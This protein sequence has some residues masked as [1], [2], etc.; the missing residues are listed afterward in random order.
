[1]REKV[2]GGGGGGGEETC[3]SV[4]FPVSFGILG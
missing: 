2:G 3:I 1:M 4:F